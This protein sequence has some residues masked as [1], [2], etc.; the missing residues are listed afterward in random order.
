MLGANPAESDREMETPF[1]WRVR[2]SDRA[3]HKVFGIVAA[4]VAAF[5][6]GEFLFK[7]IALGLI[8]FAIIFGSTAEF[9]LGS[10]FTLDEKKASVRTGASYSVIEWSDVKR[11]WRDEGGIK[12]SP[13]ESAGAMDSFRGVYLRY[14]DGN[15]EAIE[16]AVLTYGKLSNIDVVH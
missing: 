9:W 12:L 11:V 7:N 6:I 16:E 5:L 3:P 4:G 10:V 15:R 14:G 13:L 2:L 1:R 8:G